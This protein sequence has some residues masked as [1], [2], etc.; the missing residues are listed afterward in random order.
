MDTA[1]YSHDLFRTK[2]GTQR[3]RSTCFTTLRVDRPSEFVYVRDPTKRDEIVFLS[4]RVVYYKC[5]KHVS[6]LPEFVLSKS[7]GNITTSP[8]HLSYTT[9][10]HHLLREVYYTA[11]FPKAHSC[12]VQL[13]VPTSSCFKHVFH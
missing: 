3:S 9:I 5:K 12:F 10:C 6:L 7:C 2:P 4:Q 13:T 1:Q 11:E 8:R